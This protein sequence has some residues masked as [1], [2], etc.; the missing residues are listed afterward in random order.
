MAEPKTHSKSKKKLTKETPANPLQFPAAID[1]FCDYLSVQKRYS[2]HTVKSYRHDLI[3]VS[4]ALS[5]LGVT[6]WSGA[7][8]FNM[9]TVIASQHGSGLAGRSLARR[10]SAVRSL[11]KY[12]IKHKLIAVNPVADVPAPKDERGLPETLQ[13]EDIQRL[14][15]LK[16]DDILML[17]DAAIFELIYS[18][19]L[20]LAEVVSLEIDSIE[21]ANGQVQVTGKGSKTRVLPVGQKALSAVAAWKNRRMELLRGNGLETALFVSRRGTR[22]SPRSVQQRLK[23]LARKTGLAQNVYPHLLRHS[24]A[25]H[26]LESSGDLR[27]V[28]ELLGHAD[29]STTQVYTHLDFQHLAKVYE[30]AH[31]RANK[32]ALPGND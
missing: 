26:M 11:F 22:L 8:P 16:S 7:N 5:D 20:R 21:E 30:R 2:P 10:L 6:D 25:S 18:S 15:A 1:V 19:G 14:L 24:F 29:I 9:R 12:L 31:P 3:E 13:I 23:S 27:A 28:Q 17:R 4:S 32:K